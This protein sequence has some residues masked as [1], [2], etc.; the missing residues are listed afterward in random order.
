VEG[1]VSVADAVKGGIAPGAVLFVYARPAD[2]SRMPL[3]IL[4]Q[5]AGAFP[6]GFKLD[7]TLA[8]APQARLSLHREVTLVARISKSGDATPQPG[9]ITGSLGPVKVGARDLKLV[10]NEVVK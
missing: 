7:D 2:G 4:R 5:P 1:S 3:A 9:D 8:M 10:L 6:V